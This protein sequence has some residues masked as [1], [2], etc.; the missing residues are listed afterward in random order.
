MVG[1]YEEHR[2]GGAPPPAAAAGPVGGR[3]SGPLVR[4]ADGSGAE[5]AEFRTGETL[6][7]EV[8]F[9]TREPLDSPVMGVALFRDDG[10]YCYGPNTFVRRPSPRGRYDGRYVLT[11]EFEG[12]PLLGGRYEAS[13]AF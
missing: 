4:L 11:A 8:E 5:K 9:E 13:V 2:V 12:L 3:G 10:V 6:R 7:V 1:R